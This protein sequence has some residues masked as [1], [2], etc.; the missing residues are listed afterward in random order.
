M[1]RDGGKRPGLAEAT[2]PPLVLVERDMPLQAL[3]QA[4]Q[5]AQTAGGRI[6]LVSGEAGLGTSSLIQ[7]FVGQLP[8]PAAVV[9]GWCDPLHTPRPLG[10]VRDLAR[11]WLGR[12]S[13]ESD[14]ADH[15]DGLLARLSRRPRSANGVHVLVIEDLHWV[16]QRSADWLQFVGRR[17]ALLRVL[18]VC[19]LRDEPRP[20]GHPLEVVLGALPAARVHR[21][22]LQPLSGE[23]IQR[24]ATAAGLDAGAAAA[25]HRLT[26]GNPFFVQALLHRAE[27]GALDA[28]D[29]MVLPHTVSDALQAHLAGLPPPLRD[30]LALVA[31]S[32]SGVPQRLLEHVATAPEAAQVDAALAQRLLLASAHHLQ[33]RHEL[34]RL[35][36]LERVPPVARRALHRRWLDALLAQPAQAQVLEL[37]V[38]HARGAGADEV[39]LAMRPR[40]PTGPPPLAPTARP[41][42]TWPQ[43]WGPQRA[44]RRQWRPTF[45]SAGPTRPAWPM[46]LTNAP[47]TRATRRPGCGGWWGARTRWATT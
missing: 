10:P 25:L 5:D 46:V 11:R 19:S 17:L 7:A 18:V 26:G 20:A 14:D 27:P 15:F 40:P 30:L 44:H 42:N 12:S 3:Q 8:D 13:N 36:I 29:R 32:P 43:R 24:A 31:C 41:P 4:W 38:H 35:A 34:L 37:L 2:A 21:I 1:P 16:D 22:A 39:L 33:L 6:A 9:T 47:S 23:A 28:R 45:W